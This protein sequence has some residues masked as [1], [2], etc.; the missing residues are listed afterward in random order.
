M[1]I[2]GA[3]ITEGV[4]SIPGMGKIL[5]DSISIY[6]NSMV[7]G[8]TF[9]FTS[10]SILSTFLGDWLLTLVDPRISLDE[11]GGSR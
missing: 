3:L 2:S 9:I 5:P 10:L 8:L 11:K 4:Y 7:I 6:N 1:C